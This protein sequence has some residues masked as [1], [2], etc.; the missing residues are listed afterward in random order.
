MDLYKKYLHASAK[1]G[2]LPALNELAVNHLIGC[3]G[4]EKST[5]RMLWA[6]LAGVTR[7]SDFSRI[8]FVKHLL[9]A[10]HTHPRKLQILWSM[11]EEIKN[12]L[13][14]ADKKTLLAQI[15][16]INEKFNQK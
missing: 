7:G 9:D 12:P 15:A 6:C 13:Y 14:S 1:G 3:Q 16:E 8:I 11:V 2:Y 5:S 10:G 4:H